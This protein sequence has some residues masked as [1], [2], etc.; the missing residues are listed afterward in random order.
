MTEELTEYLDACKEGD[1]IEVCDAIVDLLYVL[2]GMVVAHGVQYI[3][4]DMYNE[5]HRSNMSKLENG[6]PLYRK[7]G[8]VMKGSEYF[9]PNI[10]KFINE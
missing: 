1:L 8:K 4:E 9:R 10:K 3:I 5:V 6:K 7:D 2:N